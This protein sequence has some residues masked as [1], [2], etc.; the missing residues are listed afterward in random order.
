MPYVHSDPARA[1]EAHALP[2][3]EVFE[4]SAREAERRVFFP[5]LTGAGWYWWACFPGCLPDGPPQGPFTTEAAAVADA[6]DDA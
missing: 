1:D 2:N 6:Q 4:V 3:I 5:E